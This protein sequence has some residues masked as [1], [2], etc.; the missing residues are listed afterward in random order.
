ME[1]L[2]KLK[3][4]ADEKGVE[5]LLPENL[6]DDLLEE[7]FEICDNADV[8]NCNDALYQTVI[9]LM[10]ELQNKD[11]EE[12]DYDQSFMIHNDTSKAVN[13]ICVRL[14]TLYVCESCVRDGLL[15]RT[16][17]ADKIETLLYGGSNRSYKLTPLGSLMQVIND[18]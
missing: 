17:S 14:M 7:I 3:Q 5:S 2:L 4:L 12:L 8:G 13:L 15:I 9:N 11:R 10:M 16:G 1:T 6:P 18:N